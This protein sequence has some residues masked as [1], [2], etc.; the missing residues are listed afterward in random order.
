MS[1]TY[2]TRND[3]IYFEIIAPIAAGDAIAA[4]FDIDAIYDDLE[5]R[6]LITTEDGFT[7]TADHDEF[8]AVVM[9]HQIDEAEALRTAAEKT[10]PGTRHLT[11]SIDEDG[12]Q[13][14]FDPA[15][16][17][18]TEDGVDDV[19][20]TAQA[21]RMAA[22]DGHDGDIWRFDTLEEFADELDE[23]AEGIGFDEGADLWQGMAL[24]AP[25]DWVHK[26]D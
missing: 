16:M 12:D 26:L 18:C 21:H 19:E 8:W 5:A 20:L 3:L 24:V 17:I 11:I 22:R 15:G 14:V 6:G 7:L 9:D 4:E 2:T 1:T 10:A 13:W 25:A 23:I